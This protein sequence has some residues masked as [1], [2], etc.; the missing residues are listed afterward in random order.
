M[1][2]TLGTRSG[3]SADINVTP[4][5]DVLLVLLIIFMVI[6]PHQNL[7]EA[8]DIPQPAPIQAKP[9][10]PEKAIVVQLQDQGEGKQ[11]SLKINQKQ[12]SWDTLEARLKEVLDTRAD[13]VAF[14][15]GDPELEFRYVAQVVDVTHAAGAERV[16]LVGEKQ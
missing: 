16:G 2:M 7:G 6:L 8:A 12:V 9:P 5:I 3:A 10:Q 11:P 15:K 14:V 1:S 4:L 13:K